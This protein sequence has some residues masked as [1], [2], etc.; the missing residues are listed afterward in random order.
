MERARTALATFKAGK[1]PISSVYQAV[2]QDITTHVGATRASVW[3]MESVALKSSITSLCLYDTRD[4]SFTSGVTLSEDAF[5]EYFDAIARDLK[6]VAPDA[7]THPATSCFDEVYF[8]PLD[9]RSLLDF[10]I[11]EK[12]RPVAVLCCEHCGEQKPW[13]Q[14]DLDYLQAISTVV[15]FAMKAAKSAETLVRV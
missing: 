4:A 5:P 14:K 13:S 8:A 7:I 9:I 15:G 6:I 11:L 10:V 12:G 1:S 3:S 2:C